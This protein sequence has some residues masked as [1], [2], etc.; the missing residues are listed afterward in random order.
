MNELL[1]FG[2]IALVI[3][4]I[5]Y[6]YRLGSVALSAMVALQAILAN[7]FV[8]KQMSL[9][10]WS[11]TCSDVFAIGGIL[12]L[13]LLQE[14]WG[15]EMASKAIRASLLAMLFFAAM[16]Q[17]HLLYAPNSADTTQSAFQAIFSSSPRIVISSIAVY[18]LVQKI[19]VSVFS[20]LKKLFHERVLAV[21]LVL[22]L[23][24]SQLLDTVL[25]SFLGLYGLVESLFDII[26]VSYLVKCLVIASSSAF[27]AGAKKWVKT[28]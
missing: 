20:F 8:V 14:T 26:V 15:R 10:G 6:A 17:I 13:N 5:L 2:H 16:S 27:V 3:G 21:R 9:F 1:F 25:F 4:F 28:T 12:G 19:D 11:V 7:L 24:F 23:L 22:S 18:Y